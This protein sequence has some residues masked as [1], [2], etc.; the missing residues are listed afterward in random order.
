[1]S[2]LENSVIFKENDGF[3]NEEINNKESKIKAIFING[4][5][6]FEGNIIRR[7]SITNDNEYTMLI[8]WYNGNDPIL[9][10]LNLVSECRLKKVQIEDTDINNPKN[11]Y[12]IIRINNEEVYD[13]LK[14]SDKLT[15]NAFADRF[16]H[17]F[18]LNEIIETNLNSPNY[19]FLFRECILKK[20]NEDN[21]Y[22]IKLE[23]ELHQNISGHLIRKLNKDENV[24]FKINS[25]N[26]NLNSPRRS[27]RTKNISKANTVQN[28]KNNN[29]SKSPAVPP[30]ILTR[31]KSFNS[32]LPSNGYQY[33]PS[34]PSSN[35]KNEV[36]TDE[37]PEVSEETSIEK[38]ENEFIT[39]DKYSYKDI[40]K[41]IKWMNYF[42]EREYHSSALD[43]LATYL[44][45]QKL[46]YMESKAYC[47]KRLNYLMLPAI[48]LSTSATV[49]SSS[50]KD[51]YWGVYLI[52][53]INGVIAFLLALVNYLKLDA[54]SEAH[55]ISAHQ[56]DK[57]Q[58]SIEF[59]SGTTLLFNNSKS[60]IIKKLEITEKKITEIKETNQFIVPK[61][62]RT[63]YPIIYNTN[64]FLIIKKIEDIRK[65]KINELKEVKNQK[66]Y[67]IAVL[68][69]KKMKEKNSS[70]KNLEDEI[71]RLIKEK[72]R[73]INNLL[74]L[75]SAFSIIDE[76]FIKEMENAEKIKRMTLKKW[77]FC[78]I[79]I[80]SP[81]DDPTKLNSF[82]ED[83]MDPFGRHDKYLKQIKDIEDKKIKEKENNKQKEF[84]KKQDKNFKKVCSDFKKTKDLLKDNIILTEQLYEKLERGEI[85][86]E[87]N[88]ETENK[89][90]NLKKY[91][92]IIQL[93][94]NKKKVDINNIKLMAEELIS[95]DNEEKKSKNSDSSNSLVDFDVVCNGSQKM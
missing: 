85:H 40:E 50:L 30:S 54:T 81:S 46:I 58:T 37:E 56:Y 26:N 16:Q 48:L 88:K 11:L 22:D 86:N 32:N 44:K 91:P 65:R 1:M 94:G 51:F 61:F 79:G 7:N 25:N 2:D 64:V 55:K 38:K 33:T 95:S 43:I 92:N 47:E 80:N 90:I 45:G 66:N 28:T 49:L 69:S 36:D 68:K 87:K 62:I 4:L 63:L 21:S 67:L 73:H 8:K 52:A 71:N 18:I 53:A 17:P 39:Y 14:T 83:V 3:T 15:I 89:V 10:N 5:K 6:W 20:I 24:I 78:G 77:L 9:I 27:E 60:V 35:Y 82:I 59:L 76:M 42:D 70:L 75:K 19:P 57:L 34:Q 93:F 74:V 31:K 41:E 12:Q 29:I 72:D 23:D 13:L 84:I